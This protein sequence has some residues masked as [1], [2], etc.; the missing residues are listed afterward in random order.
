MAL[1]EEGKG[2]GIVLFCMAVFATVICDPGYKLI[3]KRIQQCETGEFYVITCV[4]E[5]IIKCSYGRAGTYIYYTL[6][7]NVGGEYKTIRCQK[8]WSYSKIREGEEITL[9]MYS[10]NFKHQNAFVLEN[11]Y[12]EYR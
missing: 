6:M 7:I 2:I 3:K 4:C 9:A 12:K 11:L 10:L 1:G 5:Q 8:R